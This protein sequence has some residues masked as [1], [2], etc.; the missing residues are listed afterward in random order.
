MVPCPASLRQPA[1]DE[2]IAAKF[3]HA[4]DADVD[5]VRVVRRTGYHQRP[6]DKRRR[7][8]GPAGLVRQAVKVDFVSPPGT[9]L[10]RCAR[11]RARVEVERGNALDDSVIDLTADLGGMTGPLAPLV[12]RTARHIRSHALRGKAL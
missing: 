12:T 2:A 1:H 9:L 3:L 11:H 10:A 6:R 8:F 5:I 4:V 7:L